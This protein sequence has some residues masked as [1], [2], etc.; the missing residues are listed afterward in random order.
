[1]EK[2]LLVGGN[3]I[4]LKSHGAIPLLY[5][6][7]FGKDF[8]AEI[9]KMNVTEKNIGNMD[10]EVFYNLVF[11]FAKTADKSL[12]PTPIEW[13]ET[14]EEFPI[15]DVLPDITEMIVKLINTKKK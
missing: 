11:L 5:K 9:A 2:T 4:R 13:L 6:M 12:P 1:M 15:M 10:M 3:E 7:N 8:F 14:F